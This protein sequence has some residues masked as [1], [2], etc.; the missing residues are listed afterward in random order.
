[1]ATVI[2]TLEDAE[3]TFR[4]AGMFALA[5]NDALLFL[6]RLGV[7]TSEESR[8]VAGEEVNVISYPCDG[9]DGEDI[10]IMDPGFV[11]NAEGQWR[12]RN[13]P[14]M[15]IGGMN[16]YVV[17]HPAD[18]L[19]SA[20]E[21]AWAYYCGEPVL[22]DGWIIPIHRHPAWSID[23]IRSAWTHQTVITATEWEN[24]LKS[25]LAAL[26][27]HNCKSDPEPNVNPFVFYQLSSRTPQSQAMYLRMD[28]GE[29][30]RVAPGNDGS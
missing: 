16:P 8:Y 24:R 22:L 23:A 11:E 6:G 7:G 29:V 4:D 1:M 25:D 19:D 20:I 10:P 2:S 5:L 15:L 9:R 18:S 21:V 27:R 12:F 3:R 28:C 30:C 14:P 17:R 26:D 13:D